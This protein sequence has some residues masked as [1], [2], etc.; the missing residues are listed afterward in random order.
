MFGDVLPD[1]DAGRA[2]G[3]SRVEH[4]GAARGSLLHRERHHR[5]EVTP[6]G[7]HDRSSR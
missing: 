3:D 5:R 1:H 7:A 4:R 6:M 2:G